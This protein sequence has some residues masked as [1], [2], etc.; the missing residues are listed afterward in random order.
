[1][2]TIKAIIWDLEGVLLRTE[3]VDIPAAV[4][5]RL[6][7]PDEDVR[8]IFYGDFN[9]RVDIGE[10]RQDDFWNHILRSLNLPEDRKPDLLAFFYHD[11]QIDQQLLADMRAYHQTYQT[12]LLTNFS[13]M[14]RPMLES[15]WRVDGA[16]DEIIISCEI[17]MIKPFAGI[18]EHMLARL[19]CSAG[20]AIF[21]DDKP[22]NVEGARQ[23]GLHAIH[24]TDRQSMNRQIQTILTSENNH[25]FW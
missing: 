18:N 20:Q 23:V 8:K 21:I 25:Y 1:M 3:D 15:Q 6:K 9:D 11:F 12:G 7:V 4:A 17:G 22:G 13:D 2:T 19:G 24:F 5:R 16:F 14:L 10:Y